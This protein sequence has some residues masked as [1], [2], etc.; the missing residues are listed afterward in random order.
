MDV[1]KNIIC[2]WML[3]IVFFG[4]KR[5]IDSISEN[6]KVVYSPL[7]DIPLVDDLAPFMDTVLYLVPELILPAPVC[8]MLIDDCGNMY[9]L[10]FKGDL[11]TL[12]STGKKF[13]DFTT[14]GRAQNEYIK[15]NDI[16]LRGQP[17]ELLVLDENKVMEFGVDDT[18]AFR[19]FNTPLGVPYD[20]IAPSGKE[21]CWLFAAFPVDSRN[22]DKH[23]DYLLKLVDQD[24]EILKEILRR[25]DCTFSM[26]NITQSSNNVYYL[27][28][29]N[30]RHI[31]YRLEQD[32]IVPYYK[33][34]FGDRNIP[35]RYFF[36][37]ANN[38]IT[39]YM[40]APYFKQVCF[41]HETYRHFY[42]KCAG[43]DAIEY[44]FLLDKNNPQHGI[45][46][47]NKDQSS[48]IYI[49]CA[50][51]KY[52]YVLLNK[53]QIEQFY[54][55]KEK[56]ANPLYRYIVNSL[57]DKLDFANSDEVIIKIAFK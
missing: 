48:D 17:K 21:H 27:K 31:F 43:E 1:M 30:A 23:K 32:S 10:G 28:P 57:G 24:G 8:K 42:F 14:Q 34:D 15:I 41:A 46:W 35:P 54:G 6:A 50:D 20:A 7:K 3:C 39:K 26:M 36:D 22:L 2:F 47:I 9:M 19:T 4:C 16:A 37:D 53:Y 49:I 5:N 29:Q 51:E 25:E 38:D 45:C 12:T 56:E 40:R 55:N 33:I 13:R 11:V 44:N 18:L 52:F